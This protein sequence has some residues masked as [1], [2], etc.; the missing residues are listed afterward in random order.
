MRYPY[1]DMKPMVEQIYRAYGGGRMMWGSDFPWIAEV[2]GYKKLTELIDF[3][4]PDLTEDERS[5]IMGGT[6]SAFWFRE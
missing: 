1:E 6:A 5:M 3:H 4:L 2:P